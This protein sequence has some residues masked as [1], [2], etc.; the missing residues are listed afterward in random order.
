M[1]PK[2]T[3][4]MTDITGQ[5]FGRLTAHSFIGVTPRKVAV[6]KAV[7]YCGNTVIVRYP[8]LA[9]GDTRSCGCMHKEA[10][11]FKS[12]ARATHKHTKSPTY[13]SW[14]AARGRATNKRDK[15]YPR[16]GAVGIGMCKEWTKSF[17]AFLNDMGERPQGTSLDRI[18]GSKGYEP[19]NCRWATTKE[20]GLNRRSVTL[21][22][23]KCLADW[24]KELGVTPAAV[25]KRVKKY[26]S[27]HGNA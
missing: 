18:D 12:K 17:Q 9:R 21:F 23:G 2:I 1:T 8:E 7:C 22:Q 15:D 27:V 24:A 14:S 4:R 11:I 3:G 20:Q 5:K 10:N 19:G 25:Y 26:G 13:N 16:Y 6:W